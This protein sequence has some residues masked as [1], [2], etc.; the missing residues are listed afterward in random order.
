MMGDWKCRS[1]SRPI[2]ANTPLIT[3]CFL[4]ALET[5]NTFDPTRAGFLVTNAK[6]LV[7][8]PIKKTCKVNRFGGCEEVDCATLTGLFYWTVSIPILSLCAAFGSNTGFQS[9]SGVKMI[10]QEICGDLSNFNPCNVTANLVEIKVQPNPCPA[11][12][13]LQDNL[14]GGIVA[15]PPTECDCVFSN[16][17]RVTI[18]NEFGNCQDSCDNLVFN[19]M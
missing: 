8:G 19:P 13:A 9:V 15:N 14:I 10:N 5:G 16:G 12:S 6:D 4:T 3:I 1:K 2:N 18:P 7:L 17:Q 11:G